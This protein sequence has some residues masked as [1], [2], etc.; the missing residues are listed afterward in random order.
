MHVSPSQTAEHAAAVV[1]FAG[2]AVQGGAGVV[3]LPGAD[4]FPMGQ[5]PQVELRP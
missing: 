3:M 4:V 5:G 2:Q 1:Q